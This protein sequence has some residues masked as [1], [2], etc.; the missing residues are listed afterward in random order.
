MAAQG[1][2]AARFQNRPERL[3]WRAARL[4]ARDAWRRGHRARFV[5]WLGPVFWPYAYHDIFYYSFW[6]HAYDDAY[7]AYAY[8]DIFESVYWPSGSPYVG[9]GYVGPY[10]EGMASAVPGGG[11]TTAGRRMTRE[12]DMVCEPDKELTAWPFDRIEK[13][14]QPTAEQRALLDEL[15]QA[16]AMAA[17]V[18]KD[19]CPRNVAMTPPG[20]LEAMIMRLS[21][22]LEAIRIVRPRLEAFYN[23]LNDEQK[24]RFNALGPNVATRAAQTARAQQG[25][26]GARCDDAKPGLASLPMVQLEEVVRPTKDQLPAFDRLRE[27]NE[28][29]VGVLQSACPDEIPQTPIGRLDAMQKRLEAMLEAAK[30]VQPAL[31]EFYSALNS[32]QK[33]RFNTMGQRASNSS[34]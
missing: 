29:A 25:S 23:S 34:R 18:F 27:A 10:P 5:A 21:A 14:V 15:K 31:A 22:A 26:Q 6:P 12:L 4:A 16:A 2:F 32:E 7:W 9:G 33:A 19:A 20:R 30:T 3:D 28:K 8:D 17:R 1:R 11:R 24:A 13:A